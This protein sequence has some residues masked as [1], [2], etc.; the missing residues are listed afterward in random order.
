MSGIE[1]LMLRALHPRPEGKGLSAHL[2][3]KS[4]SETKT[5]PP[6]RKGSLANQGKFKYRV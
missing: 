2:G 5:A 1:P 4:W 6:A 3:K